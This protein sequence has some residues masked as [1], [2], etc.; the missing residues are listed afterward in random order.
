MGD[1]EYKM[2]DYE[3]ITSNHENI[4]GDLGNLKGGH[5]TNVSIFISYICR[6]F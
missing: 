5:K 3:D 4:S 1:Y 2:G 6:S